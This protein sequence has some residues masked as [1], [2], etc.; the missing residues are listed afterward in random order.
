MNEPF[1]MPR[2]FQPLIEERAQEIL[3]M[4][5]TSPFPRRRWARALVRH[6]GFVGLHGFA[7]DAVALAVARALDGWARIWLCFGQ[8]PHCYFSLRTL[9]RA[10]GIPV[11]RVFDVNAASFVHWL[12]GQNLDLIVSQAPDVL[13]PPLLHA[14]RIGCLNK[15]ASLL[16]RY[17]GLHPVFWA[18]LKGEREVG[19]T[20]HLLNERIDAGPIVLQRRLDVAPD[21]TLYEVY[22]QVF[23]IAGVMLVE[24]V[25]KLETGF[26]PEEMPG[27][28]GTYY[29]HPSRADVRRFYQSGKRFGFPP[30][31]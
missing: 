7:R 26:R 2:L 10:H 12:M 22:R 16:P 18:L 24:A 20:F 30:L 23:D 6:I 14:A 19:V 17:R 28:T 15:H 21:Q 1:F 8:R 5:L 25:H 11:R 29:S 4:G 27:K 31:W 9:A 13:K 3:G